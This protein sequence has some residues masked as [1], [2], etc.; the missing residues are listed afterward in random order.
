MSALHALGQCVALTMAL[1]CL[2][3]MH[4]R[5]AEDRRLQWSVTALWW[6]VVS[7]LIR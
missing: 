6:V 3:M 7:L 4:F 1:Y 5:E 2:V